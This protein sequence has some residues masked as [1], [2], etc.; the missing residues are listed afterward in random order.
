MRASTG[1]NSQDILQKARHNL[2]VE[3]GDDSLDI[4][5]IQKLLDNND[6]GQIRVEP[7]GD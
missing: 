2:F 6:L 5:V 4:K 1:G 3:G 7:M